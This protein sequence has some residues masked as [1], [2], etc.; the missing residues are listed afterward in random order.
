MRKG[1]I[2]LLGLVSCL[3]CVTAVAGGPKHVY[4]VSQVLAG[5]ERDPQA[6]VGRTAL[7]RGIALQLVPGCGSGYWCPSGL[8]EPNTRRP[9][10]ILL[11]EPGS[12]D[13][14]FMRL[15]RVPVFNGLLPR[16]QRMDDH[17]AAVYRVSFQAVRHTSCGIRLC[18]TALLVDTAPPY[19][20]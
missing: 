17:G 9:G 15:R 13:P 6:W 20:Q 1:A 16:P 19:I 10:P 3:L 11:L 14:L 2:A 5:V 12:T 7:V 18:L 4:T 8:Y